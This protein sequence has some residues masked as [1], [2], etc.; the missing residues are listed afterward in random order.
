[1]HDSFNEQLYLIYDDHP[2]KPNRENFAL[3]TACASYTHRLCLVHEPG[4]ESNFSTEVAA[5]DY[6][7]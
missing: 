6:A 7:G 3:I 2:K 1:M 4:I 5:R